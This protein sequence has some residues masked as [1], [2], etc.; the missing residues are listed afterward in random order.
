MT[1]KRANG[2]WCAQVS[3]LIRVP[4]T[5]KGKPILGKPSRES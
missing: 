3:L 2:T 5:V 4:E 1:K